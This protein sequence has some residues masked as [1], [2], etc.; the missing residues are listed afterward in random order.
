MSNPILT[1]E[2]IQS[3]DAVAADLHKRAFLGRLANFG[4][5]ADSEKEAAALL[6]LGVDLLNAGAPQEDP[7]Q[8]AAMDF[9]YGGGRFAS[10]KKA[11]D[12]LRGH[13]A[14]GFENLM[15]SGTIFGTQKEASTGPDLPE[16]PPQMIDSSYGVALQLARQPQ[17]Y[18]AAVVK[19]AEAEE[20]YAQGQEAQATS[21]EASN[22]N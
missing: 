7:L 1:Q 17:V 8:K 15:V 4:I 20:A 12:Q 3:A 5:V 16:L 11:Y 22:Q 6:D 21:G 2:N 18:N 9:D 14:P 13:E 10:A 19:C